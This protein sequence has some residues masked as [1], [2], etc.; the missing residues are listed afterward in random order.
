MVR[1]LI[2]ASVLAGCAAPPAPEPVW[3]AH[4]EVSVSAPWSVV[5]QSDDEVA[6]RFRDTPHG[7]RVSLGPSTHWT[8][9]G[10]SLVVDG[11]TLGSHEVPIIGVPA[12]IGPAQTVSITSEG[13]DLRVRFASRPLS[14]LAGGAPDDPAL[15]WMR[16]RPRNGSWRVITDGLATLSLPATAVRPSATQDVFI[17]GPAGTF[18]LFSDAPRTTSLFIEGTWTM[19]TAPSLQD[20]A[21]YPRTAFTYRPVS[22]SPTPR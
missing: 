9:A 2:T 19:S 6:L 10:V 12:A 14:E 13:H 18:D 5:T 7:V 15:T 17:D 8:S 3:R 11:A 21:P 16:L 20:H 4:P 1:P 22:P